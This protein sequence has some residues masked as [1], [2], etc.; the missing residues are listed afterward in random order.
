ML[1]Q[2][3]GL[4]V[5]NL[6]ILLSCQVRWAQNHQ[7]KMK[8][9]PMVSLVALTGKQ[10]ISYFNKFIFI[11]KCWIYLVGSC[12]DR[13]YVFFFLKRLLIFFLIRW[14]YVGDITVFLLMR[15]YLVLSWKAQFSS[16]PWVFQS[17]CILSSKHSPPL[18]LLTAN[19][20]QTGAFFGH[21]LLKL[22]KQVANCM[23]KNPNM[24]TISLW[25]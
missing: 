16:D 20:A 5:T 6:L 18:T 22:K 2:N 3:W 19:F 12:V 21:L 9:G 15:L 4:G 14:W 10:Q 24:G 7:L 13:Y 23:H 11:L 17:T 1:D 25:A 8:Y